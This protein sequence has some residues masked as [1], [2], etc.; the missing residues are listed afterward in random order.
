[1]TPFR[2]EVAVAGHLRLPDRETRVILTGS[3]KA[4]LTPFD[5][6]ATFNK[7]LTVAKVAGDGYG[8]SRSSSG[9]AKG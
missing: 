1:V 3:S 2:P 5:V 8:Y 4:W 9:N 7:E 6:S